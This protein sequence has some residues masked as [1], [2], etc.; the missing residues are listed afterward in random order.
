MANWLESS[1][2]TIPSVLLEHYS[3][4]GLTPTEMM[5][6]LHLWSNRNGK[7]SN[8]NMTKIEE[9]MGID[10]N[11]IY[12]LIQSLIDKKGILLETSYT[13]NG[14]QTHHYNLFPLIDLIDYQLSMN[15]KELEYVDEHDLIQSIQTEFNHQLSPMELELVKEWVQKYHYPL[16]MLKRALKETVLNKANSLK[17]MDRILSR[18]EDLGLTTSQKI[19]DYLSQKRQSPIKNKT[20]ASSGQVNIPLEDWL[21]GN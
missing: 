20:T 21:N 15:D 7:Y 11:Q 2:V 13:T 19:D 1:F 3:S 16:D 18:W 8:P 5:L 17:Y 12:A 9:E 10:L 6:Y 14:K 4:V